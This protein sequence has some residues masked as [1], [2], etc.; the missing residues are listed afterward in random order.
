M[1]GISRFAVGDLHSRLGLAMRSTERHGSAG[2]PS[3]GI[4]RLPAYHIII[5]IIIVVV[6]VAIRFSGIILGLLGVAVG[7]VGGWG[8]LLGLCCSWACLVAWLLAVLPSYS[9]S[10]VVF[11]PVDSFLAL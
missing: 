6:V 9:S 7:G 11:G 2:R 4:S 3:G 5:I 10:S 1:T 8:W